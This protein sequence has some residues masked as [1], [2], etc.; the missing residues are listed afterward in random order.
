MVP[1][2]TGLER[3]AHGPRHSVT[4]TS[5]HAR[6]TDQHCGVRIV[7]TRVHHT[8]DRARE[9]EAGVFGHGQG[10]HVATQQHHSLPVARV[11]MQVGD[12]RRHCVPFEHLDIAA[13]E[14]V[15]DSLLGSWQLESELRFAMDRPAQLDHLC[16][17]SLRFADQ[18]PHSYP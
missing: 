4:P 2:F 17:Q 11:A 3:E 15:E 8:I 7:A 12:D 16:P 6:G 5:E 14:R 18:L 10:I 13:V 1:F 9:F